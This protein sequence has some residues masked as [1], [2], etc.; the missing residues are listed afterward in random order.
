MAARVS[1]E[2]RRLDGLGAVVFLATFAG[3]AYFVQSRAVDQPRDVDITP[4][5]AVTEAEAAP[6]DIAPV[7]P[8]E[9]RLALDKLA[10]EGFSQ[11]VSGD[12]AGTAGSAAADGASAEAA[13]PVE[14]VEPDE[15]AYVQTLQDG[16]R[17]LWT[18]DPVLQSSALTIFQNREVP[19]AGAVVLDLEDNSV[20]AFAG[21]SSAY[22]LRGC[23]GSLARALP[24][25]LP[26]RLN[27]LQHAHYVSPSHKTRAAPRVRVCASPLSSLLTIQ[28]VGALPSEQHSLDPVTHR[29]EF[30][31]GWRR[32][33]ASRSPQ[34]P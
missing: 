12:P 5:T 7:L 30:V 9:D 2:T 13:T 3:I 10:L 6:E 26:S 4:V 28:A 22:V 19:Y 27:A 33:A 17:V 11:S 16:H 18:L 32:A 8:W 31:C 25:L 20:L 23:P 34:P 24:E 14:P 29:R 21:H 1:G 15:A